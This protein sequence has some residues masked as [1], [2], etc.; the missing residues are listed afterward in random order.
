MADN[1]EVGKRPEGGNKEAAR[2]ANY[3]S[4]GHTAFEVIIES[5]QF[6]SGDLEPQTHTRIVTSPAYAK[7]FHAILGDSLDRYELSF[8]P[9]PEEKEHE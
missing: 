4:V 2:Y 7:M 9:I 3:F 5:G 6:Y 1:P 8:G